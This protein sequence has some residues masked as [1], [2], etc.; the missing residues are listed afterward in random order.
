MAYK[1]RGTVRVE[2]T[3]VTRQEKIETWRL[4]FVPDKDHSVKN[5]DNHCAVF[6][7]N[8]GNHLN[9]GRIVDLDL[10]ERGVSV[11]LSPDLQGNPLFIPLLSSA[12]ATQMK[13]EIKVDITDDSGGRVT[14]TNI[15]LPAT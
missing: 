11:T 4:G 12:V 1:S 10:N 14:L 8:G 9:R 13:V 7:N 3:V 2:G 15:S 5:G 6:F